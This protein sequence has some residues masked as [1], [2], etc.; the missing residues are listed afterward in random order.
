M[1]TILEEIETKI[2]GLKTST[3]KTNVGVVRETGLVAVPSYDGVALP[4]GARIRR[5]G[6]SARLG[7]RRLVSEASSVRLARPSC[8]SGRPSA[9]RAGI[10]L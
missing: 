5:R 2:A 9:R 10:P 7:C 1:S 3:T 4:R 8:A 6:G